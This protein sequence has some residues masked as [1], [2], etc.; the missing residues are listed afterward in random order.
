M[1]GAAPM[2]PEIEARVADALDRLGPLPVLGGTVAQVRALADDP[3]SLT[4]DLVAV[5]DRDEAFALNLLRFANQAAVRPIRARSVR[6]AVTLV[7]RRALARLALEAA[8][9]Q[10]LE[11]VPGSGRASRGQLHVHATAV[12]A[13]A[14][15][16]AERTGTPADVVH[17]AGLLH[18]VGK[19]ILPLAFPVEQV[20]AIALGQPAGVRRAAAERDELGVD[21]AYAGALL[22]RHSDVGDDVCDAIALH[23]GGRS[24]QESPTREAACVQLGNAI[25]GMLGGETADDELVHLALRRLE[26]EPSALDELAE[27][28]ALVPPARSGA[29]E[30]ADRIGRLERLAQTDELTDLANRRHWLALVTEELD[31]GRPG[32]VLICDVDRFK[33]VNDR[34]G[35]RA[36]D[37][38]L[39]ELARVLDRHGVPGRLGGDEFGIWVPGDAAAGRAA[40]EALLAEAVRSLPGDGMSVS[41]G[42]AAAEARG[43]DLTALL[44]AADRALYRAKAGGRARVEMG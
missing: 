6:Q 14:V 10:F 23:H 1:P 38:L 20:E 40:A 30:L 12:A 2:R 44:E 27:Q 18:D 22:G 24:S 37:L 15:S 31:A 28:S 43:G 17:L 21:H 3:Y 26:L 36:G 35:H 5:I 11:R 13:C 4:D 9:Y 42:V 19:L 33:A 8:T 41:V 7:G 39:A 25:V 16:A 34:H 32:N 29:R